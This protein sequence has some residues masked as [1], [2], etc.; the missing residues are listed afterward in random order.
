[1]N[2]AVMPL[3]EC[4]PLL[5]TPDMKP[6]RFDTCRAR[7]ISSL[8]ERITPRSSSSGIVASAITRL[9]RVCSMLICEVFLSVAKFDSRKKLLDRPGTAATI[10]WHAACVAL[11]VRFWPAA[12][13]VV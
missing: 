3:A 4:A 7:Y 2:I 1:M 5:L 6:P 10:Q 11:P 8:S 9:P 12:S 13:P